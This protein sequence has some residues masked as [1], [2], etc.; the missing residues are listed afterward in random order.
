MQSILVYT[1]T[2]LLMFGASVLYKNG[3][4][5]VLR[6]NIKLRR[7][8]IVACI[9][10]AIVFGLR[11]NVG[12]DYANYKEMYDTHDFDRLEYIFRGV[13]DLFASNGVHVTIY[14]AL[15]AFLQIFILLK[16]F[17]NEKFIYPALVFTLFAGQYFLLWM[18]V[19]RQDIAA[20]IFIYSIAFIVDKKFLKYLICIVIACGFHKTAV[21]LL[22]VYPLLC[23]KK[24]YF[25][26]IPLQLAILLVSVALG[27]SSGAIMN[28]IDQVLEPFMMALGY[29]GYGFGGVESSISD[30]KIGV[31]FL[32]TLALDFIIIIYSNRM[33]AFYNNDR[34]LCF[35]DLYYVGVV[36]NML[37][38]NSFILQR[39][40]RYFRFFKMIIAAY[41][42]YYLYKN[43]NSKVN[44][45]VFIVMIALFLLLY[46]SLFRYSADACYIYRFFWQQ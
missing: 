38:A 9:I 5:A 7:W 23:I 15:W 34:F 12:I 37:L 40:V 44:V 3:R 30:V 10:F 4:Y 27:I 31:S 16:S 35:Y 29:E 26:N 22:F 1:L 33:K 8:D 20:C 2:F 17:R 41:L 39:P 28:T 18:N 32:L 43:A 14:F 19:I 11:Y 46:V 45:F 36:S 21:L 25:R 13:S 24:N 42:L 6:P